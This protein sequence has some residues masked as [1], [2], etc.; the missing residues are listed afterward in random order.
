MHSNS[1]LRKISR[2]RRLL[3]KWLNLKR[4]QQVFIVLGSLV[5]LITSSMYGIASW[6]IN[7]HANEPLKYGITFIPNYARFLN[8]E[9]KQTLDAIINDLGVRRLRFVSYWRETEP[10]PG[11]YDFEEL[12]W[13]FDMAEAAGAEVSLAIGLRQPRWPECHMPDW[14][15][16][17]PK[18]DWRQKIKDQMKA[19]VERYKNR[20]NLVEYQLEN[21]Y[22]LSVF[23]VCPDHDRDRLIDEFNFVK[24][25]D[26]SKPLIV[27]RSNN[28]TPSWPLGKPR[29]DI[30]GASIYKRVWDKT[31]TKRYF[32]YPYPGWFYA[33]LAGAAELTTGRNTFIHE[34]QAEPWMPPGFEMNDIN[35]I[36]EQNKSM[37][38]KR[39]K[40]RFE[41]GKA[42][43]M[44]TI[45]LWGAE[46][47]YWRLT[48]AG[49]PS[50]WQAAK[51]ELTKTSA[52]NS[53]F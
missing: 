2:R 47:W 7:R 44:R 6:Y 43:G 24:T 52:Q 1:H 29:A 4:W 33:F 14:A 26:S 27:T 18:E 38:A 48:K 31:V 19:V 40:S 10:Q 17:L 23:G 15:K 37:D 9:P 41:Y 20:P 25:I 42:T 13:Q 5:F 45:D 35:S 51:E 3:F 8:L 39:L 28:A 22:F 11:Q 50:L 46:W 30:N 12:D 16:A 21:E 53:N 36:P 32:E 49:D 34:L